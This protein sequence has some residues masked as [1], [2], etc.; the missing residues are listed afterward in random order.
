MCELLLLLLLLPLPL[1]LLLLMLLLFFRLLLLLLLL[2]WSTIT[3]FHN[4]PCTKNK[5]TLTE[6]SWWGVVATRCAR[7]N[8]HA[9]KGR[10]E[11]GPADVR[12]ITSKHSLKGRGKG[13]GRGLVYQMRKNE[14]TSIEKSW[15]WGTSR[16]GR[17]KKQ[18]FAE[19][20]YQLC[21][22]EPTT[23]ERP[24]WGHQQ[25]WEKEKASTH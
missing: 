20:S 21:K 16:R 3:N 8:T 6:R 7:T 9:S 1:L 24:R 14:Q 18:A 12:E 17:K 13:H 4:N 11:G 2:S 25:T 15:W 23:F 22:N 10:G 19:R 5:R